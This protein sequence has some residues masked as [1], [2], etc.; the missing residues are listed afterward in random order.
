M[1]SEWKGQKGADMNLQCPITDADTVC[2]R[3]DFGADGLSGSETAERTWCRTLDL[4]T[5]PSNEEACHRLQQ[6][7]R[8]QA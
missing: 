7:L 6:T 1:S 3:Q 8:A 5:N 2:G 4:H